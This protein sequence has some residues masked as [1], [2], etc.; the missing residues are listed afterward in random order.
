MEDNLNILEK[1]LKSTKRFPFQWKKKLQKLIKKEMRISSL[2]FFKM[3]FIER[4][5]FMVS[6]LSILVDNLMER[7]HKIKCIDCDCVCEHDSVNG[8][9]IN[10]NV[11]LAIQNIQTRLMNNQKI[12]LRIHLI[13]P[14]TIL[15]NLSCC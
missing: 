3:R 10:I 12:N 7:I 9:F 13:F 4:A 14:I 1:I 5:R 8:S 2:F 6:S 15:I 11:Y